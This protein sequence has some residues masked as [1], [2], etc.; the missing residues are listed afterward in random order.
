MN[1][2]FFNDQNDFRKWLERDHKNESELIVGYYKED[3]GKP[4]MTWSQSVDEA[5]FF[6]WIDGIRKSIDKESYCIRFT[7]QR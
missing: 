4:G 7:P 1:P 5:L 3:T 2:V 6:G